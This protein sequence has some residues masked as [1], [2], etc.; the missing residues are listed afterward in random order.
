[1]EGNSNWF[2][3]PY[4]NKIFCRDDGNECDNNIHCIG[5]EKSSE[6]KLKRV[7]KDVNNCYSSITLPIKIT[8]NKKTDRTSIII[9]MVGK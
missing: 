7:L 1:M 4:N 2:R 8:Y 3:S 9:T 6:E 5:C